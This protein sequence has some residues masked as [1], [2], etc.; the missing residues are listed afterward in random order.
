M[1]LPEGTPLKEVLELGFIPFPV[2]VD[3]IKLKLFAATDRLILKKA[4]DDLDDVALLLK[5][6]WEKQIE[7]TYASDDEREK[8]KSFFLPFIV[9]II[10]L[11]H[12]FIYRS[13]LRQVVTSRSNSHFSFH[14]AYCLLLIGLFLQIVGLVV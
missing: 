6:S 7:M 11:P 4:I 12:F 8:A 14:R 10:C 3:A 13:A 9:F 5:T 1:H 2:L